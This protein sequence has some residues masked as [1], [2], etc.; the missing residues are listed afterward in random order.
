VTPASNPPAAGNTVT[1]Q[2]GPNNTFTFNPSSVAISPG[3]TVQWVWQSTTIPHTV[4]SGL[5]GAAD[6]KFCSLPEG[7]TENAQTCNSTSYAQVAPFTYSETDTFM[8]PGMYPYYCTVHGA[9]MT[10]MVIVGQAAPPPDMSTPPPPPPPPPTGMPKTVN[11]A[12]GPNN[13]LSFSPASVDV[14]VGD[15]VTWT[16]Q[17]ASIPHTVTSGSPGAADGQFCS[18]GGAQNAAACAGAGYAATA[19]KSFSHTFTVVGSHA[20][21]CAVH[22]AAMTGT[23][24]VH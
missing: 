13:S 20:Y 6:G 4:T 12:V 24:N 14:N 10:G 8:T 22:G 17:S 21:F 9:Q 2:V 1:V 19:P 23:V 11:V 5:P 15:T 7:S 3:D 16:W 18:N